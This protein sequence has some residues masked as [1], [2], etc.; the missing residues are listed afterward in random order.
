MTNQKT[1][2]VKVR[3]LTAFA[4]RFLGL[5]LLVLEIVKLTLELMK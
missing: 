2:Q 1:R 4:Q 3:R 5:V